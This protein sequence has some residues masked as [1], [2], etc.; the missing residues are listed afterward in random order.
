MIRLIGFYF[1]D[2]KG[3]QNVGI[4]LKPDPHALLDFPARIIGEKA[5]E[6]ILV[7]LPSS[8]FRIRSDKKNLVI[9]PE[10]NELS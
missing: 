6:R 2:F 9:L 3:L 7:H 4:I 5:G 8:L 10:E 1:S